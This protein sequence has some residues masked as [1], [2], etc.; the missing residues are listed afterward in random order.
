MLY[1]LIFLKFFKW[2]ILLYYINKIYIFIKL[3]NVLE[4]LKPF[5][6]NIY[7]LIWETISIKKDYIYFIIFFNDK[8]INSYSLF[9]FN[10]NAGL[11]Y[12]KCGAIWCTIIKP[13]WFWCDSWDANIDFKF[14]WILSIKQWSFFYSWS[15]YFLI[16]Y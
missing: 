5:F 2:F 6:R 10:N 3:I 15:I 16:I 14:H 4:N 13:Y 8:N 1:N 7:I 11:T 9:C 12:T